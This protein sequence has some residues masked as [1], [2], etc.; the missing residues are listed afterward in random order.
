[1][2]PTT[3]TIT[4]IRLLVSAE[5]LADRIREPTLKVVDVRLPE[6]Y[7]HGHIPGAINLPLPVLQ[8]FHDGTPEML[9]GQTEFETRLGER[10]IRETDT[11]VL[12]DE[13]WG[14]PAARVLWSLERYGHQDAYILDGGLD[15]WKAEGRPLTT[16]SPPSTPATYRARPANDCEASHDWLRN[17]VNDPDIVVVDTRTPNEYRQGHVPGAINWD[18]MNA[19]PDHSASTLRPD[20]ELRAELE[21]LGV[22]PDKE[23]VVYCRSGTRSA[24]TYFT[25]RHLGFPGVRNYDGSWL[26]W[27]IKE[28]YRE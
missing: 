7:A 17:H 16:N 28:R 14:M 18:W 25:L 21:S 1:M 3:Q 8:V 11:I 27:S 26:A 15:R 6:G 22:T 23:I 10:G 12:Y 24:H 5:W 19:I 9:A 2:A 4:P 20:D 13:M